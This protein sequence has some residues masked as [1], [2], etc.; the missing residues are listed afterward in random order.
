MRALGVILSTILAAVLLAH[1]Q[2]QPQAPPQT[3]R[4]ALLEMFIN[5]RPGALERHLPDVTRKAL[6]HGG[7]AA[8]SDFLRPIVNFSAGLTA[9]QK[10]F[11]T[12]DVGPILFSM[13]PAQQDK[14]IEIMVERDDLLGD[15]DEIEL[16]GRLY[17]A[18]GL[19]PL[20]VWPSFTFLM[21]Q[22]N[23]IWKLAE[24][25]V[26]LRVPFGNVEFLQGLQKTQNQSL[27]SAAVGNL[28]TLNTAEVTYRATY[29]DRGFT[30]KLAELGGVNPGPQPNSDH[31]MLIDD[32][33][34]TG[35]KG[36]YVFSIGGCDA[37]P[38]SRYQATA[39]PQ[40]PESGMR[41]FCSDQSALIRYAADGK[42]ATCLSAGVPL[43]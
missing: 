35:Q 43:P 13:E 1:S 11:E 20:P 36:G 42:P 27:E 22:E 8:S 4:Q 18:G 24:M 41:A 25:A 12:F 10:H 28:R 14:K 39:V 34:A 33:L 17:K 38:A 7:D 15:V 30:C 19:Q 23:D 26:T 16:S 40:N 29:P 9:N 3:A 2:P 31:A 6:L 5:P 21:K 37:R 32:P